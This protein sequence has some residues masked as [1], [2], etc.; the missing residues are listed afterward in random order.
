MLP[1][2]RY[3]QVPHPA[4][5]IAALAVLYFLVGRISLLLA[6]PPGY[7][8]PIWPASGIALAALLLYGYRLWPG[9][10][11]GSF[12]TNIATSFDASTTFTL[13]QSLALAA[14]IGLGASLQALFGTFLIRRYIDLD[15]GLIRTQSVCGFLGLGG[16]LSCLVNASW[17]VTS[18][19]IF[20]V[21]SGSQVPY[22][23]M[24]WWVGDA[25]GVIAV[26]PLIFIW[27]GKPREVWRRRIWGVGLPLIL[28]LP[29]VIGLFIFAS[30]REQKRIE[31]EHFQHSITIGD[32]LEKK[33][34]SNLEVLHSIRSFFNASTQID[35]QQFKNLVTHTLDRIPEIQALSW[36]PRIS[37][38]QRP[39]FEQAAQSQGFS[40]FMISERDADG[41]LVPAASRPIYVVVRYIEPHQE[42]T[43]A[44]G[45][46]AYSNPT[47]RVAMDSARDSGNPVAT[48][49]INLVQEQNGQAGILVF[50]PIYAGS[51]ST[52][53]ESPS[54]RHNKL[55]GYAVSVLHM[56]D[57]LA[58][59]L[60]GIA[61]P[62]TEIHLIDESASGAD[63]QLASYHI[64]ADGFRK[65]EPTEENG[66]LGNNIS[67]SKEYQF[68]S[69][70]W[71]L[72]VTTT[73]EYLADK[74]T[75]IAWITLVVGFV[76]STLLGAFL[77]IL[78]GQSYLD[79]HR[80]NELAQAN[81][82]LNNEIAERK[83]AQ[84]E[85]HRHK[86][87]LENMVSEQTTD[88]IAAKEAAE[89]ANHA[90][91][92][93]LANMSHELR[94]PM[95]A[96]LSFSEMGDEKVGSAPDEKLRIYFSRI[97]ESGQR[98]LLL[99][100]DLL[101]LSKLEAENMEFNQQ[102]N[103][104]KAVVYTAKQ[105]FDGLLDAKSL[106]LE[107]VGTEMDTRAW[108][109]AD[110]ILQVVRNL[111]SNAIKFTP[112][113][114]RITVSFHKAELPATDRHMSV[115]TVPAIALTVS[116]QGIGIPEEEL[117]MVFNKFI[118][119]SKTRTGAGGT[120]LGLAICKEIVMGHGGSIQASNNPGGGAMVTL[121]I[122]VDNNTA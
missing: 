92:Q 42:N 38:E 90:K 45:Y 107:I 118:Q 82:Q 55:L 64:G 13:F 6:I 1:G 73:P 119:S 89:T 94:T 121:I 67:W 40:N 25:I 102:E 68:G 111:L 74:Q 53:P 61:I 36:N 39:I 83:Q 110:K 26:L 54:E 113:R 49:R 115:G 51:I 31:D 32:S 80:A 116:D 88:L 41:K 65:L 114:K 30:N 79:E 7:S 35:H 29:V 28:S 103:D 22:S 78:T 95:H 27:L 72:L 70:T 117:E 104:L 15:S 81:A 59:A 12:F 56:G 16:P 47:R 91:S 97:K 14:S 10:L 112:E 52:T 48:A 66:P 122:P 60:E 11:L 43:K 120:G 20:G 58:A 9:I 101:D 23:W 76:L 84:E 3:H 75:W 46:D 5:Q 98:L 44:L 105:E 87:Q 34:A 37:H 8:T 77:L 69:R 18:L 106:T 71:R 2:I 62:N 86:Q 85:L 109:D 4:I 19:W 21:I 93:F 99:L 100:N 108:F 57:V 96:I 33:L 24:T 63:R 17:S 50:N